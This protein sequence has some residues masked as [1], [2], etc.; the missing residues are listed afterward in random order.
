MV[1]IAI[2]KGKVLKKC[3]TERD[4]DKYVVG[5]YH[6]FDNLGK[7]CYLSTQAWGNAHWEVEPETMIKLCECSPHEAKRKLEEMMIKHHFKG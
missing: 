6:G 1:E 3:V 7:G 2:Y 4:T 5:F